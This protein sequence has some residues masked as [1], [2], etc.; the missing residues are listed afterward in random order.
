MAIGRPPKV[1]YDDLLN[2]L[3]GYI[4]SATPPIVAEYAHLHGITRQRLYSLADEKKAAGDS[5]L[6]DAIRKLSESKEIA[7]ERGGLTGK[8]AANMA[9]FSLKQLGWSD[10]QAAPSYGEQPVEDDPLTKALKEEAARMDEE[11]AD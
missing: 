3:D 7:L 6:F 4:A 11:N 5:R 8:Y 1:N 2:D 9:I 10:K